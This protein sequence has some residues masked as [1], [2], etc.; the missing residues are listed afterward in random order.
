MPRPY[1]LSTP[2]G[3]PFKG[4][5]QINETLYPE[6]ETEDKRVHPIYKQTFTCQEFQLSLSHQLT[7]ELE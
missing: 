4:I 7:R 2:A 6:C 1:N 5:N 3:Y